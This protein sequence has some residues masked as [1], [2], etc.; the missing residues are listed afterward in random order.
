MSDFYVYLPSN[1]EFLPTNKSNNYVTKLA[2]EISLS[3][4]WQVCMKEIHYPRTWA[5]LSPHESSFVVMRG[6]GDWEEVNI[7]SG[8]YNTP[9][10]LVKAVNN[11]MGDDQVSFT[12]SVASRRVTASIPQGTSVHFNEPL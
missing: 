2:K 7:D 12:Y 1:T 10:A 4:R 9:R 3:G 6:G 5:T 8:Y 11:A